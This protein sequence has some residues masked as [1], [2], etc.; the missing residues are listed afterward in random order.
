M[1]IGG[2]MTNN[3]KPNLIKIHYKQGRKNNGNNINI[4]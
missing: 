2:K 4:H 3:F 1:K